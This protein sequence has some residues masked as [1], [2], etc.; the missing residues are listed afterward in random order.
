MK[1][2][3]KSHMD[4]GFSAALWDHI[5]ERY[6]DKKEFFIDTFEVPPGHGTVTNEL[7]GPSAGDPPV[8]ESEVV[9]GKRGNRAWDSRLVLK[10]KRP[11]RLVRVIAGPHEEK[12][13]RCDG[14]GFLPSSPFSWYAHGPHAVGCLAEGCVGGTIKHACILYTAYGVPSIDAPASP[15]E[16]GDLEAQLEK[17]QERMLDAVRVFCKAPLG[18][19][20]EIDRLGALTTLVS[21]EEKLMESLAVARKF[22]SE[23]GLAAPL[24]MMPC[25]TCGAPGM[26][27]AV[28]DS[29]GYEDDPRRCQTCGML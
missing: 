14:T 4:H 25:D 21:D 15:K 5:F 11:T 6:A 27:D 24:H 13:E 2:H 18:S 7:Y 1:K 12:C 20:E 23:H 26:G 17:H 16:P 10:P 22:W 28:Y 19:T 9:Y 3:A 29:G 8:P